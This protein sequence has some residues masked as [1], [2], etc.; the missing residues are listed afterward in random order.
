[1]K[2]RMLML[3]LLIM[4]LP[5]FIGEHIPLK[6]K[7]G[8]LALSITIKD[9]IVFLLPFMVFSFLF[10]SLISF[11][12]RAVLFIIMLLIMVA[13]SNFIAI[14]TGYSIAANILPYMDFQIARLV[15]GE[16]A[17]KPLFH[18]PIPKLLSNEPAIIAGILLGITFALK[19][20]AKIEK[21]GKLMSQASIQFLKKCFIPIL[22]IFI[23]GFVLKL[24]HDRVLSQLFGVY[25]PVVVIIITTQLL[26]VMHYYL[27]AASYNPRKAISYIKNVAPAALTGFSTISSAA[28]MPVTISC[29][30]KNLPNPSFAKVIVPATANIHTIGSAIGITIFSVASLV[31]FGMGVPSFMSFL[32]FAFYYT[33]AKYAVAGIPGG[34]ILIVTPLLQSHLGFTD[35]MLGLISA[36]Y[37]LLDPFGTTTNVS[38][39]G[40][41]A[42]LFNKMYKSQEEVDYSSETS[43]VNM[44]N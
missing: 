28:T 6:V 26:Y 34:V 3:L 43:A 23:L 14:I 27:L 20:N 39:N 2:F 17:L 12:N 21:A 5:A 33:M 41:F 13:C 29:T 18:I 25:G 1:M 36:V 4:I 22:P 30:E 44:K 15:S 19:R 38:G 37:L 35:E 11:G 31:A 16:E 7:M 9:M 32:I 8:F 42:I 24:E 10:S 40:A